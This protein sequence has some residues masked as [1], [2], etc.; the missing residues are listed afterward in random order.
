MGALRISER[1]KAVAIVFKTIR[2]QILQNRS[3]LAKLREAIEPISGFEWSRALIEIVGSKPI[4]DIMARI[5]STMPPLEEINTL[6]KC[7]RRLFG[8]QRSFPQSRGKF[9]ER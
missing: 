2:H 5:K 7:A 3:N 6:R 9:G 1:A 4:S 8:T